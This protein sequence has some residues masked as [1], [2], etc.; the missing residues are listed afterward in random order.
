MNI[1]VVG[2]SWFNEVDEA[3]PDEEFMSMARV[4]AS[5][6]TELLHRLAQ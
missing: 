2:D 3:I 5:R 4:I 6:R 1:A